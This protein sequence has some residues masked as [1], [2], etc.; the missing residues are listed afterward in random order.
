M[1]TPF[2]SAENA[3]HKLEVF[4]DQ[5]AESPREFISE[6]GGTSTFIIWSRAYHSPDDNEFH[7]PFDFQVWWSGAWAVMC[8]DGSEWHSPYASKE[9]AEKELGYLVA[10][11]HEGYSVAHLDEGAGVGGV[12]LP[13]FAYEHGAIMYRASK[14]GNPCPWDSGQAGY[15]YSTA[16]QIKEWGVEIEKVP[17]YLSGEVDSYSRWANGEFWGYVLSEK[18]RVERVDIRTN[19][20]DRQIQKVETESEVWDETDS[21]WGF[22]YDDVEQG[23]RDWLSDYDELIEALS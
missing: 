22:D 4:Y 13:V 3:T 12:C 14:D 7:E 15:I 20:V 10:Q 2:M 11:G 6:A 21:C 8:P 1:D 5:D 9:D 18:V 23:L 17:E 16:D 19:L